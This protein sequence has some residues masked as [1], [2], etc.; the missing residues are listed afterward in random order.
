M[1]SW[2]KRDSPQEYTP[3]LSVDDSSLLNYIKN[4]GWRDQVRIRPI[5]SKIIGFFLPETNNFMLRFDQVHVF[6]VS[7]MREINLFYSNIQRKKL[8]MFQLF[9]NSMRF[10]RLTW[11]T[12]LLS[13]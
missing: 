12:L 3:P 7:R 5:Q 13:K 6:R 8:K 1:K 9:Q 4:M 2:W 10:A 11:Q